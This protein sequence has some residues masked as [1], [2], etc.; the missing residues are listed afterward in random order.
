MNIE[1]LYQD[2]D[3][4]VLN[5]PSGVSVTKDRK[6]SPQLLDLMKHRIDT[7]CRLRLVHR[8]DKDTSGLL[9]LAKT[10]QAQTKY[11]R[12]FEERLIRKT[13]LA[14]VRGDVTQTSGTID[15]PLMPDAKEPGRM[16]IA[17]KKGK[18]AVTEWKLLADFGKVQLL[19]V[20]PQT[21]RT[22]QIRVHLSAVGMPLAVDPLYS[23]SRPLYLS[24]FKTDYRLGKGQEERPLIERL[25]LHAYLIESPCLAVGGTPT[26]SAG[27]AAAK[28]D[29]FI[30][31]L[32]KKFAATIKM[33]TRHNPK[34]R[35]AWENINNFSAI[36]TAKK[37]R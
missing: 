34:G 10:K 25:T 16:C 37:L 19:A 32:D 3:I 18:H 1:I 23:S 33:L 28:Q 12:M 20:Y 17:K 4:I 35:T 6:G 26:A 31:P 15:L 8:L 13:Y 21:G 27:T 11:C 14:I 36:I 2:K 9:L 30:A 22:H 5:K 7:D 24:E 29:C